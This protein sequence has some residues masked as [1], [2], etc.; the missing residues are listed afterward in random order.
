M[1]LPPLTV[2]DLGCGDGHLTLEIAAWA[3]RVVAV[4]RSPRVL[5]RAQA[6]ARRR[7]VSNI[8]WKRGNM[9][10][11]PLDDGCVD[12]AV[13]SQAL[14]H[15]SEPRGALSEARRVVTP[16]GR[17]LVLDLAEHTQEWVRDR[18]GDRWLGFS[19]SS[20]EDLMS[21]AGLTD[22]VIRTGVEGDHFPVV[23]AVGTRSSETASHP[24]RSRPRRS[25]S[26]AASASRASHGGRLVHD[27]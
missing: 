12:V 24:R 4:D 22:V 15:V 7:G 3:R 20:L 13:L 26:A 18:F 16:G 19:R 23:I 11:L 10:K 27:P 5:S 6:L 2:A 25:G 17:V 14:H 8:V 9:E 21:Q 1:L